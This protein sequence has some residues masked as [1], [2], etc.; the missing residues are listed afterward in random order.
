[1]TLI[2][3]ICLYKYTLISLK[4]PLFIRVWF[5]ALWEKRFLFLLAKIKT[6]LLVTNRNKSYLVFIL[7]H[8]SYEK[9]GQSL[10][11]LFKFLVP[12]KKIN[13]ES[14]EGV[15]V[16]MFFIQNLWVSVSHG[17]IIHSFRSITFNIARNNCVLLLTQYWLTIF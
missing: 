6:I 13:R 9:T 17:F 12:V 1:M 14:M 5:L 7:A 15:R 2:T 8:G 4:E 3:G 10:W 16:G 11:F